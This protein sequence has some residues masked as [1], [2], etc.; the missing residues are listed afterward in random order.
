MIW[1]LLGVGYLVGMGASAYAFV[2]IDFG[3]SKDSGE[4]LIGSVFLWPIMLPILAGLHLGTRTIERRDRRRALAAAEERE[5]ART[6]KE[7]N[8]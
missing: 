8:L 7:H 4:G 6:L 1:I 5:I 2:L 3:N